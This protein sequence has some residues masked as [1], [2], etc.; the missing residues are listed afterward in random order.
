MSFIIG[1]KSRHCFHN[2]FWSLP[3]Q[4]C[5]SFGLLRRKRQ[6][7]R[8]FSIILRLMRDLYQKV[9]AISNPHKNPLKIPKWFSLGGLRIQACRLDLDGSMLLC[10][11]V[12]V[13]DFQGAKHFLIFFWEYKGFS[14]QWNS[15]RKYQSFFWKSHTMF[16]FFKIYMSKK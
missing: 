14:L 15:D 1:Q 11:V 13:C 3:L 2:V 7:T 4:V 16:F 10:S 9:R 12:D 8:H 5:R 6:D